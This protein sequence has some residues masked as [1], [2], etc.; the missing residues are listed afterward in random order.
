MELICHVSVLYGSI[1]CEICIKDHTGQDLK[2]FFVLRFCK[3]ANLVLCGRRLRQ[4]AKSKHAEQKHIGCENDV[5]IFCTDI[6]NFFL[7]LWRKYLVN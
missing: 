4:D 3:A 2:K 1:M 5:I 6:W 7:K